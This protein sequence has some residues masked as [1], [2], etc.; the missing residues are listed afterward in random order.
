MPLFKKINHQ[1]RAAVF[2][3]KIEEELKELSKH[4]VL[5]DVSAQRLNN[6][7]SEIHQKGFLSIRQLLKLA[8]YTDNDLFYNGDGKP[9]LTDG[10]CI[11]I[12]HSFEYAAIVISEENV[13]IDIEKKR[14]KIIRIADKFC[15]D[16]ELLYVNSQEIEK[17]VENT[18]LIWCAK[19]SVF[20]MCNTRGLSFK[21]HIYV[22]LD[23]YNNKEGEAIVNRGSLQK[24][25]EYFS[26]DLGSF[27]MTYSFAK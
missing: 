13:G 21:D 11:S 26:C 2:V 6:M 3:W 20:K 25:F 5:R 27:M 16:K 8:G 18:T 14:E 17:R 9:Y 7:K 10:K 12:T 24:Q 1:D 15:N 19:E 22:D 23:R 4:T